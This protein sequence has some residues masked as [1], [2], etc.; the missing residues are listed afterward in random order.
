MKKSPNYLFRHFVYF[1]SDS[2]TS[3]P[4]LFSFLEGHYIIREKA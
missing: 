2:Y 3:R 1:T 4:Y